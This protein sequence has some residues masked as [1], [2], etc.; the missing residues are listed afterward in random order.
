MRARNLIAVALVMAGSAGGALAQTR[1]SEVPPP[2]R[3]ME[4]LTADQQMGRFENEEQRRRLN[5]TP[6][7]AEAQYGAER[8]D[9]AR[10]VQ[11]LIDAGQCREAR[12]LAS[13]EGSRNMALRVRQ[14]CR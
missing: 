8:M 1:P 3:P 7:E 12:E 2:P 10:R 14:T 5:P 9:L 6:E 13:T 4:R 11:V